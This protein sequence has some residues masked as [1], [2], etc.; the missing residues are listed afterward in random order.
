MES[1]SAP[2]RVNLSEEA[3]TLLNAQCPGVKTQSRGVVQVKGKG[4]QVL[5]WL[6]QGPPVSMQA[7][8]NAEQPRQ[9]GSKRVSQPHVSQD[10]ASSQ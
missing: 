9:G 10:L 5:H 2:D 4:A 1:N 8:L 6:V 7:W 3:A